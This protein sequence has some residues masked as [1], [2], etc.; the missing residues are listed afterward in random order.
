MLLFSGIGNK[1]VSVHYLSFQASDKYAM[2]W[3]S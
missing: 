2:Y 1:T 3:W